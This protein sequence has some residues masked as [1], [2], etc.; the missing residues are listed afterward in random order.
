MAT[1]PI[2]RGG[3]AQGLYAQSS[4][5]KESLGSLRITKDGRKFRYG[6]A[7]GTLAAGNMTIGATADTAHTN[8]TLVAAIAKGSY[9]FPITVTAGTAI[10]ANQLA[11]GLFIVQDGTG[12]G[13]CYTIMGNSA[14]SASETI[15][16]ISLED[17]IITALDTTSEV[18]LI[19]NPFYGVR[20]SATAEQ[21]A[22]GIPLI[23]VTSAYYCWLQ[24]G[25]PCCW[26]NEPGT[27]AG[28]GTNMI[29]GTYTAGSVTP[30]TG[31]LTEALLPIVGYAWG[32]V[33][34]GTQYTPGFLTID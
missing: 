26:F 21:I 16:N 19:H 22:T 9:N 12:E 13:Q 23:A 1:Q 34:E 32:E 7:G 2:K 17:P 15:V 11:D 14:I 8:E 28:V 6:K 18:S 25:G 24:T 5:A 27:A 3:W 10:A 29:S 31:W 4:S 30:A 33:G 20:H